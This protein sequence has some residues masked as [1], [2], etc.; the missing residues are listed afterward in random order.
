MGSVVIGLALVAAASALRLD[1]DDKEWKERPVAKVVGMLKDMQTTLQEE[2]ENDQELYDKMVC[3]CETNDKEK[4][5]AIAT[6]GQQI[7]DLT[8]AIEEYTSKDQQLTTDIA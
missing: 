4:T 8:A 7:K 3:W 5:Q 1:S 6:A 2:A